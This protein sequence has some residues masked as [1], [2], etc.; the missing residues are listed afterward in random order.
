MPKGPGLLRATV[1]KVRA[2]IRWH[3][4]PQT[5]TWPL[6]VTRAMDI[7]TDPGYSRNTLPVMAL[8]GSPGLD[9][10]MV[11]GSST[12][13]SDQFAPP[14]H[15]RHQHRPWMATKARDITDPSCVRTMD[16]DMAFGGFPGPSIPWPLVAARTTQNTMTPSGSV[17]SGHQHGCRWQCRPL[18]LVC[19]SPPSHL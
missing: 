16:P 9:I 18:V 6:I 7:N 5:S 17:D 11:P 12:G 2:N 3:P 13:H 14:P 4:Q 8:S 19:S 15:P 10:T 1:G